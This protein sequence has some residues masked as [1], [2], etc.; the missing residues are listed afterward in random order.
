MIERLEND[1]KKMNP[2]SDN[3][4]GIKFKE[5]LTKRIEDLR[6]AYPNEQENVYMKIIENDAQNIIND[7]IL[8]IKRKLIKDDNFENI[9][10]CSNK[11]FKMAIATN[12]KKTKKMQYNVTDINNDV[13]NMKKCIKNVQDFNKVEAKKLVSEGILDSKYILNPNTQMF[14]LRMWRFISKNKR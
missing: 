3:D 14:S 5:Y 12:S 11:L 4:L 2:K 1:F 6:S 9:K 7:D 13:A 8:S 10:K